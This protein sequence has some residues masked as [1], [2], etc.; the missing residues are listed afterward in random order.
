MITIAGRARFRDPDAI[1]QPA[2][3]LG[4]LIVEFQ[5]VSGAR[6]MAQVLVRENRSRSYQ[7]FL[8]GVE[9][10]ALDLQEA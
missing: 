1:E 6:R 10:L 4:T 5:K 7:V 8:A 9:R 3:T 2:R